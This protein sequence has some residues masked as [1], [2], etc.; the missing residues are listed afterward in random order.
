M[1]LTTKDFEIGGT[2]PEKFTCD[3]ENISPQLEWSDVPE[4]TKSF[5]ILFQSYRKPA[6]QHKLWLIC[7]IPKDAREIPQ[8]GPVPGKI[9][10]NDFG[11]KGYSGPCPSQGAQEYQFTV[12][13][14]NVEKL[15]GRG[16]FSKEKQELGRQNFITSVNNATIT[17]AKITVNYSKK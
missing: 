16:V 1:N 4:E 17:Y 15:E 12:Y 3:G 6:D 10:L 13:A 5:A 14:L 2:I 8:N 11:W 9:I 7:D